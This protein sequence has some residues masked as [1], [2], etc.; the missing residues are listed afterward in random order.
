M[1]KALALVL[2]ALS[3]AAT[4]D[5]FE[6]DA[7]S[8]LN[9]PAP[10]GSRSVLPVTFEFSKYG[11]Y[12]Q[13]SNNGSE[14]HYGEA[15]YDGI[16]YYHTSE[17]GRVNLRQEV[18]PGNNRPIVIAYFIGTDAATVYSNCKLTATEE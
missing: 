15:E 2:L 11:A 17:D 3:A 8:Q 13:D 4:A 18:E 14:T 5:T 9:H 7:V 1:Q 6:C 12:Q 10:N 16:G